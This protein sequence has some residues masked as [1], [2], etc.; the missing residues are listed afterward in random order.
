MKHSHSFLIYYFKTLCDQVG[1]MCSGEDAGKQCV[2]TSLSTLIYSRIKEIHSC[3]GIAV[4]RPGTNYG[5]SNQ[6]CIQH[7]CCT[8][9]LTHCD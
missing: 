7:E 1:I 6:Y 3:P 9:N 4:K 5:D 2:P 8:G